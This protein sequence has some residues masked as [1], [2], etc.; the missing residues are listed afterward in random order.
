MENS[1]YNEL[2]ITLPSSMVEFVA[3]YV[4]NIFNDAIEMGEG[5]IIVRSQNDIGY[6][7]ESVEAL[8]MQLDNRMKVEYKIQTKANKDWIGDYQNSIE[9]I[10]VGSFYI[11]PSWYEGK[12]DAINIKI[13][14]ALAFGSGHHATTASCLLFIEK[15]V[16]HKIAY[17]M[18]VAEVA[19]WL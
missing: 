16:K 3:D 19:F 11:Y 7:K 14:P 4:A 17:L 9:P 18:W 6:V 5:E 8:M 15:Y 13:D 1:T 2:T 10:E 12:E